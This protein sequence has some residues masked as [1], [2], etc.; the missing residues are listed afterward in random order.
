M[1]LLFRKR[2]KGDEEKPRCNN[3]ICSK[4]KKRIKEKEMGME[5]RLE[6]IL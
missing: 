2:R 4:K 1:V 6:E 3:G 5:Q